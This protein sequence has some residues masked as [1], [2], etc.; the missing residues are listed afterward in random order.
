MVTLWYRA[1]EILDGQQYSCEVD[2]WSVGCIFA[3]LLTG[4]VLFQG[5]NPE[6]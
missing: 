6:N 5:S 1:P 2:L 3:E 4:A